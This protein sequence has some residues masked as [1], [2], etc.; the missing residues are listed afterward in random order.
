ML[1]ARAPS[2]LKA[3][4][5]AAWATD[6]VSEAVGTH[7]NRTGRVAGE[8][9][10]GGAGCKTPHTLRCLIRHIHHHAPP[11]TPGPPPTPLLGNAFAASK[12]LYKLPRI[13]MAVVRGSACFDVAHFIDHNRDLFGPTRRDKINEQVWVW[14][15]PK[16]LIVSAEGCV[17]AGFR[18]A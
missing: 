11:P 7:H 1:A 12:G 8:S 5:Y 18:Q 3:A 2:A 15:C 6:V 10:L 14:G 16:T 13:L 4:K 9:D 17:E